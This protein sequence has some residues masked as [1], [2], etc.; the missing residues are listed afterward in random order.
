MVRWPKKALVPVLLLLPG[1][2][3]ASPPE[4]CYLS[5]SNALNGVGA[6]QAAAM[7]DQSP[8]F[9]VVSRGPDG[10]SLHG[11]LLGGNRHVCYLQ[12]PVEGDPQ[13]LALAETPDGWEFRAQER[14]DGIDC[15]LE[16]SFAADS[17]QLRDQNYHCSRYVFAC[18]FGVSLHDV[19]L[20]RSDRESCDALK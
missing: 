4:G 20:E 9:L 17:I 2:A 1:I 11:R 19:Q 10:L 16:V 5:H 14:A 6:G 8:G 13:P 15:R 12:A 7:Q 18:G 3:F